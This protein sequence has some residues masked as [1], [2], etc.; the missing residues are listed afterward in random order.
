VFAS[1]MDKM[2]QPSGSDAYAIAQGVAKFASTTM[3]AMSS[4]LS[5]MGYQL[6]G[7]MVLG[8]L[9]AMKQQTAIYWLLH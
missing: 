1:N 7:A 2:C 4:C 9:W 8:Q 3:V 6:A 5:L